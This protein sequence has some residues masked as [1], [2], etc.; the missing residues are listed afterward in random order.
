MRGKRVDTD[1]CAVVVAGGNCSNVGVAARL[2]IGPC[3]QSGVGLGDGYQSDRRAG[4]AGNNKRLPYQLLHAAG[5][6]WRRGVCGADQCAECA[7]VDFVDVRHH[8]Q[9]VPDDVPVQLRR[10]VRDGAGIDG[11][12]VVVQWLTDDVPVCADE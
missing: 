5:I 12:A 6:V 2:S 1:Q 9:C 10:H 11:V 7:G 4:S 8:D 3:K